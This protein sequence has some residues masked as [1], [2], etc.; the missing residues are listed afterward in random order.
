MHLPLLAH[1]HMRQKL[2][3]LTTQAAC[4]CG[5]KWIKWLDKTH[6]A[7]Y[8]HDLRINIQ[9][10][11]KDKRGECQWINQWQP[12]NSKQP[13]QRHLIWY[14]WAKHGSWNAHN[15]TI[16]L[17]HTNTHTVPKMLTLDKELCPPNNDPFDCHFYQSHYNA[18]PETKR[19]RP[20]PLI[21]STK[22][23]HLHS[24]NPL[25]AFNGFY[26]QWKPFN[27]QRTRFK[28]KI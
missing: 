3:F 18:F 13:S 2:L 11:H 25:K 14:Q 7:M 15:S 20:L 4:L 12:K 5:W 24:D 26:C 23:V 6:R 17:D 28:F 10:P 8:K 21:G 19:G 22:C 27:L 16:M 1:Y 9:R